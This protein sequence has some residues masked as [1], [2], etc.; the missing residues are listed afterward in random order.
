MN[1]LYK[2]TS[3][4]R[5]IEEATLDS[6]IRG[7]F[8]FGGPEFYSGGS[9]SFS[10]KITRVKDR[11]PVAIY[12]R[13]FSPRDLIYARDFPLAETL[14]PEL[15]SMLAFEHDL[16]LKE[17]VSTKGLLPDYLIQCNKE[18]AIVTRPGRPKTGEMKFN[19]I[20][21]KVFYM[22]LLYILEQQR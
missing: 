21:D 14:S 8:H 12:T 10:R 5:L 18:V 16:I 17:Q 20:N 22:E 4:E 3:F 11:T 13:T 2:T 19:D 15:I 6:N 1:Y 7:E 9:I